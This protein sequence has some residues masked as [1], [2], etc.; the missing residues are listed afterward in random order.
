MDTCCDMR[1]MVEDRSETED[2]SC[3]EGMADKVSS[4]STQ[5]RT[6]QLLPTLK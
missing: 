2:P 3:T 1:P 5:E 6:L 4:S